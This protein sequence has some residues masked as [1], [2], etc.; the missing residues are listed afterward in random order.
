MKSIKYALL[1]TTA[2]VALSGCQT[3]NPQNIHTT[4]SKQT[5]QEAK[6]EIQNSKE[7][8][9]DI[10]VYN[11]GVIYVKYK[12][13]PGSVW[14]TPEANEVGYRTACKTLKPFVNK[15]MVVQVNF[16]GGQTQN[17][18]QQRCDSQ[19]TTNYY[20]YWNK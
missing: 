16:Q 17:Y 9:F 11:N 3:L 6:Q 5:I 10:A 2:A 13:P 8:N 19:T 15:G 20:S 4:A 12:K 7:S 18:N 1:A 14:L